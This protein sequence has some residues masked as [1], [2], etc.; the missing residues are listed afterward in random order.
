MVHTGLRRCQ[1]KVDQPKH[2][3]K[4]DSRP[5]EKGK[6]LQSLRCD[7]RAGAPARCRQNSRARKSSMH[8]LDRKTEAR[9]Q[10]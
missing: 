3:K 9:N 1:A 8:V 5:I 2:R 10:C 7:L 6:G 4:N